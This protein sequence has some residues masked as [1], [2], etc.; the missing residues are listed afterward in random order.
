MFDIPIEQLATILKSD[1][2]HGFLNSFLLFL[3]LLRSGGIKKEI[4]LLKETLAHLSNFDV[5]S[6][7]RLGAL[8]HDF[9]NLDGRLS[10]VEKH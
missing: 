6:E 7:L 10:L 9:K 2:G 8:E 4:A 5:K 3:I 1:S